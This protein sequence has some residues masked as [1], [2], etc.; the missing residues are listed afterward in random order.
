MTQLVQLRPGRNLDQIF[1]PIFLA[2][3]LNGRLFASTARG[4]TLVDGLMRQATVKANGDD[5]VAA[6]NRAHTLGWACSHQDS[7][8]RDA[9]RD[10]FVETFDVSAN[11]AEI[12][13]TLICDRLKLSGHTVIK[14]N[15]DQ[16]LKIGLEYQRYP[17]GIIEDLHTGVLLDKDQ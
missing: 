7:S 11:A 14:N 10:L 9:L 13:A 3:S 6:L 5:V 15:P 16:F 4:S 2:Q 12:G 1:A 17:L 8:T